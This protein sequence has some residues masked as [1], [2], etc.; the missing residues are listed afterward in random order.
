MEDI[1]PSG[2]TAGLS[3]RASEKGKQNEVVPGTKI[4][5][6]AHGALYVGGVRRSLDYDINVVVTAVNEDVVRVKFD[7]W[8]GGFQHGDIKRDDLLNFK[9]AL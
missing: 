2:K 4:M 9:P 3:E 1:K 6:P 8:I 7:K 5:I